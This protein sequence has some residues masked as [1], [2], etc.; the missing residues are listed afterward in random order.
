NTLREYDGDVTVRVVGMAASAASVIA[1]AGDTVQVARA[2][3][4]M[5]HNAWTCVCGNRNDLRAIADTMEEFDDTMAGV[6]AAHTGGD[7]ADMAAMMD[8]ETW[9]GGERAIEMGFADSLLASDEID[10]AASAGQKHAIA[11]KKMDMALARA[12]ISRA[13][14]RKMMSEFKSG[15]RNATGGGMLSAADDMQD[16]VINLNLEPL[17]QPKFLI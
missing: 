2:G 13:D 5:I 9:I 17:A 11:A 15:T 14:R 1:M 4:L 10:T 6:Y 3:F 8:A 16:A 12:G 7:R